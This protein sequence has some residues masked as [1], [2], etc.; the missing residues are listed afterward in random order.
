MSPCIWLR[1]RGD[2]VVGT[3]RIVASGGSAKIGRM[4]VLAAERKTGIGTRLME[5]AIEIARG[6]GVSDI[7]LHAQLTAKEFYAR[8][9]Y[10]EEGEDV[11]GGGHRACQHAQGNCMIGRP[12]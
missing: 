4:A 6:M 1:L 9:G 3:L 5:H 8:L 11:R 12:S 10:R 7:T 2:N